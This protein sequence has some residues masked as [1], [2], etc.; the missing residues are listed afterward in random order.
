MY[1]YYYACQESSDVDQDGTVA[2]FHRRWKIIDEPRKGIQ[3]NNGR[4]A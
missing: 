1:D 4:I 2:M 3:S